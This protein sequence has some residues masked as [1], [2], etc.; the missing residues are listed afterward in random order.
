MPPLIYEMFRAQNDD[1]EALLAC[2]ATIRDPA[3][4][5]ADL[6]SVPHPTLAY[7]GAEDEFIELAQQQCDALPCRLEIVSGNH[8]QV[9]RQPENILPLA[10]KHIESSGTASA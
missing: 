7:Y 5:I 3:A 10:M 8:F 2:Y 6:Q 9:F 4:T 1:L